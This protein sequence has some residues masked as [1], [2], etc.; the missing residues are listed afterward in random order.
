MP[1]TWHLFVDESGDFDAGQRVVLGG[2]LLRADGRDVEEL[3]G[4][5]RTN[6]DACLPLVPYP[7]HRCECNLVASRVAGLLFRERERP[8][9]RLPTYAALAV[10][11]AVSLLLANRAAPSVAPMLAAIDAGKWPDY[12]A[13]KACSDWLQIE[14]AGL[15]ARLRAQHAWEDQ[16]L[17]EGV[18]SVSE[19]N[20]FAIASFDVEPDA[21]SDPTARYLA[22]LD[23]LF[24]RVLLFFR[25]RP[26]ETRVWAHVLVR[27]IARPRLPDGQLMPADVG[28]SVERARATMGACP[29]V[30]ITPSQPQ[31][32]N[33]GVHPGLVYADWIVNKLRFGLSGADAARWIAVAALAKFHVAFSAEGSRAGER[34]PAFVVEGAPAQAIRAA[35]G[36]DPRAALVVGAFP[37][38]WGVDQ[39]NAWIPVV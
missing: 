13:L 14:D 31:R 28:A 2:W 29:A 9:P 4:W 34:K 10:L 36:A 26:A 5:L 8:V 18:G 24:E 17:F 37:M 16:A 21:W 30:S 27:D 1:E 7:P 23:A 22:L 39:A 12:D 11:P 35:R 25:D 6:L 38:Q 33:Q 15:A 3:K 32:W 20:A 19:A